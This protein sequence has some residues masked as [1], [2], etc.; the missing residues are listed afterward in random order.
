M[1]SPIKEKICTQRF[2]ISLHLSKQISKLALL[3]LLH[4]I[5]SISYSTTDTIFFCGSRPCTNEK[6][7]RVIAIL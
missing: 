2:T 4:I 3:T 7:V 5:T 6:T 1:I